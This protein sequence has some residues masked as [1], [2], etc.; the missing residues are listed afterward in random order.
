[1]RNKTCGAWLLAI[2]LTMTAGAVRA[3]S[4]DEGQLARFKEKVRQDMTG[5]PNYTCLETIQRARREPHSRNFKPADTVRLEV[6]SVAGKELFAWPGSRQFEDRDVTSFVTSGAIGTGMF[7][8]FAQ[9]IFV[10]GKGTLQYRGEERL[11]G[12]GSVR[13]DF[14]LTQQESHWEMR[15]NN[16]SEIVAAKG[17]FWFDPA[18]LDLIRLEVRGEALP[19][20]LRLE[21]AGFQTDYARTRI[22][23][24]DALL[25]KRSELTM[26]QFSGAA[27]R[28]VTGF[29]NCHEYRTESTIRFDAPSALPE[30]SKPQVREVDLPVGLLVPIEL[31]S[32]IDSKTASVGD[33]LHARV[34][35]E[36]RYKGDLAVPRGARATGHIR[37]LDRR[38]SSTPFTVGIEFSEVEWDGS[39]AAFY[40]ELVDLD[41]KSAGAHRPL[42]YYDGHANKVQIDGEIPGVGIFYLDAA[43]FRIPPGFHMLWRTRAASG[44]IVE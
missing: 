23:S 43:A 20:S 5:I 28:D 21:E 17:S 22:G 27:S 18:S 34:V 39:R 6:S 11:A 14:H 42:T 8:M 7:A 1:M 36:V 44:R 26:T 31:E 35:Q 19:Y 9:N 40:A 25:P 15:A 24:A 2:A 37:K 4:A 32:A 38:S 10:A 12:R 33:T 3:Q 13:Y 30:V 41:R 16:A 29:S